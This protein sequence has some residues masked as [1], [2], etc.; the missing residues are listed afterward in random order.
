MII[1]LEQ[2]MLM[3]YAFVESAPLPRP[4]RCVLLPHQG[5]LPLRAPPL[6]ARHHLLLQAL[7]SLCLQKVRMKDKAS[8]FPFRYTRYCLSTC[9]LL[10]RGN[11]VFN[12][13]CKGRSFLLSH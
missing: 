11:E 9:L 13:P 5:A 1:I 3:T 7:P 8:L 4:N 10:L 6:R 12:G 2:M